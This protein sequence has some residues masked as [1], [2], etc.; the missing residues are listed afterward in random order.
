MGQ[1]PSERGTRTNE[2][3]FDRCS[4]E[5]RNR[6]HERD[7][8]A[9]ADERRAERLMPK[10]ESKFEWLLERNE[11]AQSTGASSRAG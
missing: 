1:V 3:L 5:M 10:V 2:I 7:L 9:V 4:D 8:R 11:R 6:V